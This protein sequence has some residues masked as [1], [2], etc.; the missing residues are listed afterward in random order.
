MFWLA[1]T[2]L[3]VR[4]FSRGNVRSHFTLTT[5]SLRRG[6]SAFS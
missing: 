3:N 6:S 1:K 5:H 2:P 4:A